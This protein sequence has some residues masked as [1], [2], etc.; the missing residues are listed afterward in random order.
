LVDKILV[1]GSHLLHRVSHTKQADLVNSKGITTG[2][3]HGFLN[4]IIS[5]SRKYRFN[6]LFYICWD[7]GE[8]AFRTGIFK[9]YKA[10]RQ[11]QELDPEHI[12][13]VADYKYSRKVLH[14][15]FNLLGVVSIMELG[16]EAD[17]LIGY[18]SHSL[19]G[20]KVI[21]SDDK[22]LLQLVDDNVIVMRAVA[23]EVFDRAALIDKYKLLED[24]YCEHFLFMKAMIGDTSDGIPG[25]KGL[26]PVNATRIA[27]TFITEGYEGLDTKNKKDQLFLNNLED[28]KRNLALIDIMH[29]V[30]KNVKDIKRRV[31][32]T[33]SLLSPYNKENG[34][35]VSKIL[36]SLELVKVKAALPDL[37]QALMLHGYGN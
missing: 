14:E 20:R 11:D 18:L 15:I 7:K 23:N 17:D 29:L 2:L 6:C 35:V 36:D 22:D 5:T 9:D 19:P 30:Y 27:R 24:K 3:I 1:D 4:S 13:R 25:I 21:I 31:D 28:F 10:N 16:Y 26:G 33:M 8:S 12:K 37:V 32:S 34:E